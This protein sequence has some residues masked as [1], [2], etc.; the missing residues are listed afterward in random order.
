ML[1][2]F[3][4]PATFLMALDRAVLT[5]AAPL[6]QARYALTLPELG[7][8]FSV[9]FWAYAAM[10]IP[11][12]M[13]AERVGTRIA[14]FI[15]IALW[16]A[17]TF[18]TPFAN[19]FGLLI[20]VRVLLGVGQSA[21]WPAAMVGVRGLFTERQRPT[22]NGILLCAL[23][24]GPAIGAPLT[25]LLLG[26]VGLTGAFVLFGGIGFVFAG[27]WLIFFRDGGNAA[28]S[29]A[30]ASDVASAQSSALA[31]A[32]VLAPAYICTG[33]I[34]SFYLTWFPT[35]LVKARHFGVGS[36]GIYAGVASFALC[37]AAL[38]AGRVLAALLRRA[39]SAH[40]T[41]TW[42]G[43]G[44]LTIAG[45]S[46]WALPYTQDATL[47]LACAC[48]A[49]V[50]LGF[51]QVITW[52]TVQDLGRGRTGS[53]TGLVALG[54]NF[55][56]GATPLLSAILVARS[57]GWNTSFAC[58]GIVGLVGAVIWM[59]VPSRAAEPLAPLTFA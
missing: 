6:L 46:T 56:A 5:V 7:L 42:V 12:G 50:A 44:S 57:G 13:F 11:A 58:L 23:Y 33:F 8:L 16:S 9:F 26:R 22:A 34:L 45:L 49:V 2:L 47:C 32:W 20:T 36:A 1:G 14:L 37:L 27:F 43:T 29:E 39:K 51:S 35:Y 31:R 52:S 24:T 25:G 55:A 18:V 21:D 10:Q 59:V 53:L 19:S 40:L 30:T 15:A 17:M 38:L 28:L 41:R 4:V 3:L 54:G 48:V